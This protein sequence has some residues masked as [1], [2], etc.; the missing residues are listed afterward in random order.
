M[1]V[2]GNLG[3]L[4]RG[5]VPWSICDLYLVIY[6][7][8]EMHIDE[9]LGFIGRGYVRWFKYAIYLVILWKISIDL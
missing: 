1:L 3:F 7:K 6:R 4:L 8:I 9:N 2:D 5:C